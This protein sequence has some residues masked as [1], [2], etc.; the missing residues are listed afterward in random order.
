[1]DCSNCIET[2]VNQFWKL[3]LWDAEL[4]CQLTHKLANLLCVR[5]GIE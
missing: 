4:R 3:F 1:M 2:P 5:Q